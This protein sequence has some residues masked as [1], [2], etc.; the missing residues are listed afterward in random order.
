MLAQRERKGQGA[1]CWTDYTASGGREGRG[2]GGGG[3]T[4]T[5]VA[6]PSLGCSHSLQEKGRV[7][8]AD[9]VAS[10]AC[11]PSAATGRRSRALRR[12]TFLHAT[13]RAALLSC[14]TKTSLP[15]PLLY[16]ALTLLHLPDPQSLLILPHDV[17]QPLTNWVI[18]AHMPHPTFG[19]HMRH[20]RVRVVPRKI[21]QGSRCRP[22]FVCY[23][24]R[25]WGY[26]G[27]QRPTGSGSVAAQGWKGGD[28]REQRASSCGSDACGGRGR[29]SRIIDCE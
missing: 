29:G 18:Q 24:E 28:R 14:L 26:R 23:G 4:P 16:I 12:L 3:V 9:V 5:A 25:R 22:D 27:D 17:P 1:A 2:G 10:F 15:L 8:A 13:G 21:G 6:V 7:D 19:V 11:R 20:M